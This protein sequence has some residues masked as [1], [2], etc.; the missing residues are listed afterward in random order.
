MNKKTNKTAHVLKLLANTEGVV[1]ENPIL[2]EDFKDEMILNRNSSQ[3]TEV[4]TESEENKKTPKRTEV[5]IVSE[6]IEENL[7]AI[8]ERF[9]CCDCE[10]CQSYISVEALNQIPPKYI[11]DNGQNAEEIQEIKEGYKSNV[12]SVLVKIALKVK[13]SPIH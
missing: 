1:R 6:L 3:K 11:L 2:N 10:K 7:V 13:N 4:K 9:R 5:N 8:L 12:I